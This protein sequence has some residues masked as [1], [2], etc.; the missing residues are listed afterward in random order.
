MGIEECIEFNNSDG[1]SLRGILHYANEETKKEIVVICLN[2]GLNDMVGWHR[3]QVK[4]S[5]F[6]SDNGYHVLRFDDSGIGDSDGDILEESI[7][8]VFSDI[9]SGLFVD[10]A[11]CSVDYIRTQ[12]KKEKIIYLGFCGGGLTAI[13]AAS[14]D[15]RIDGLVDIGGPITLSSNDY[16]QKVDPWEVKKNIDNYKSKLFKL[17]PWIKFFSNKGDYKT[18]FKSLF[19]YLKHRIVGEY[20]DATS[21]NEQLSSVNLNHKAFKNFEIYAKSKRP[22]LFFYAEIDSATWEFK[23]HFLSKYQNSE[24]WSDKLHEFIEAEKANH[25]LSSSDSQEKLKTDIL[26][27]LQTNFD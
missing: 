21:E 16:L 6:L 20:T 3:L 1:V 7:V 4:V 25:I 11:I 10:N 9:E 26:S 5:R 27:W 17:Q 22:L 2:T 14:I 8:E 24:L 12:F 19:Y 13:H 18:V 15:E 23:K